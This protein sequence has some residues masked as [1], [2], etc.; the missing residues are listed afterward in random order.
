LRHRGRTCCGGGAL[1]AGEG[2]QLP[3][4]AGGAAGGAAGGGA[5]EGGAR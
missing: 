3:A 2:A 1:T 5:K 4:T